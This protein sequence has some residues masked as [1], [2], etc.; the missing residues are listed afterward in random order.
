[1]ATFSEISRLESFF[2]RYDKNGD[3]I[4]TFTAAKMAYG[5]WLLSLI[6]QKEDGFIPDEWI[7]ELPEEWVGT[8]SGNTIYKAKHQKETV[9]TWQEFLMAN[10]LHLLC[11][12]LNTVSTRPF[13]PTIDDAL[14]CL[15]AGKEIPF[16]ED[17]EEE[18]EEETDPIQK[19]KM[20]LNKS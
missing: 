19:I 15:Y 10:A 14:R 7:G 12:R 16:G 18:L 9:V 1:M 8:S 2:K 20:R 4:I 11:A 17:I 13:L 6:K 5:K 3:G